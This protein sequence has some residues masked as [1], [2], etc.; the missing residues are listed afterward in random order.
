VKVWNTL[1]R[2]LAVL[3]QNGWDEL[4]DRSLALHRRLDDLE[5]IDR[6]THY[7]VHARLRYGDI[8]GAQETLAKASGLTKAASSGN[9]WRAFLHANMAR[10]LNEE[11]ADEVLEDQLAAGA[12]PYSAWLYLQATARQTR[13]GRADA[14]CRLQQAVTL[15][16]HEAGGVDGNYNLFAAFLE[17]AAA[18]KSGDAASWAAAVASVRGFF[19]I[20]PDHRN[21]YGASVNALPPVPDL[22][23]AEALLDLVPYF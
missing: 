12:K 15:L 8:I 22:T 14:L 9:P 18:A 1:G 3:K 7:L 20:A 13:R 6:T 5:S 2:A 21:Y 23:A 19:S 10:L 11:W 17:L 16:R 4:F